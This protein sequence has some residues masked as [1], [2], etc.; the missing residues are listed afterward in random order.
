MK[1]DDLFSVRGKRVVVTGGS[2]GIGLMIAQGFVENGARV[3]ISGRRSE[4]CDLAVDFLRQLGECSG[5]PA[6]LTSVEGRHRLCA[7]IES[8]FDGLD[9]LINNA[10]VGRNA[11][12]ELFGIEDY[13]A[14]MDTNV[15][16]P[17]FLTQELMPLIRAAGK[18]GSPA[19][20]INVGSNDGLR[21]PKPIQN[22][23]VY[24]PSKASLHHLTQTLALRFGPENITFNAIAPGP[25]ES[26]MMEQILE[27]F[28][29]LIEQ[30][31][32]MRR[33]GKPSDMAGIAIYLASEAG[34]Y[35]NGA[36]IPVDGG[37][38]VN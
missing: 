27:H 29:P 12:F 38:T 36:I 7:F 28:Q 8:H 30:N 14:A 3:I 19:R 32:P 21:V 25:F 17:F 15:K 6:D 33:I 5:I 26:E 31:C 9:V 34:S 20:V 18:P 35:V 24:G 22:G 10:G 4:K 23:Y 16:A 13:D 1:I 37:N 2:S 11:D